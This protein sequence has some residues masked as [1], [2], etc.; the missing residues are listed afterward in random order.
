MEAKPSK[1]VFKLTLQT[2]PGSVPAIIRLR[3]ALKTLLRAF[4]L[5]CISVEEVPVPVKP[6]EETK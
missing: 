1:P 4:G 2:L 3:G 6:L 5:K